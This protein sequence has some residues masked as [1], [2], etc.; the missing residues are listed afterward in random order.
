MVTGLQCN[1]EGSE[2]T[3]AFGMM[4]SAKFQVL[5]TP[6][7]LIA[8]RRVTVPCP[9]RVQG[10]WLTCQA[11]TEC[12]RRVGIANLYLRKMKHSSIVP[13]SLAGVGLSKEQLF[14]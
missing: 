9:P 10:R 2:M 1:V 12:N 3:A 13:G 4:V 5:L 11:G 14:K 6:K 8:Q 7:F